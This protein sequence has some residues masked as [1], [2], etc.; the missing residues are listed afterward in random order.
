MLYEVLIDRNAVNLL[1]YLSGLNQIIN[2][3]ELN[4]S[5]KSVE[6]LHKHGLVHAQQE[7]KMMIGI[8]LKGRQ[9]IKLLDEMKNIIDNKTTSRKLMI[10]Y[11]LTKREKEMMLAISKS[12]YE[13]KVNK[14]FKLMKKQYKAKKTFMR[15]LNLLVDLNLIN[16]FN[17]KVI[18]SEVGK[19]IITNE[20]LKEYNLL[21]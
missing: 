16:F 14:L 8:S 6:I 2:L 17:D 11:S 20:I 9:F 15:D 18:L 7:E 4:G 3:E 21:V 1:K 10:D 19:K 12:I 5:K 13:V